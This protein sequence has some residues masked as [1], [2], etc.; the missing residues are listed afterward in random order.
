[1]TNS[2]KFRWLSL[3]THTESVKSIDLGNE[4]TRPLRI[5]FAT[6]R[7]LPSIGGTE[8]HTY[9]VAT[10]AAA[11]GC[12]VTVLTTDSSGRL[13]AREESNGI[14]ILRVRAWPRDWDYYFAPGIYRTIVRGHWDLIHCQGYHTLLA[15][16]VMLAAWRSRTPYILTFH[17]GGHSSHLRNALRGVQR[18]LL[19]PL[20]ARAPRLIAV[21]TFEAEFFRERLRLPTEQFVVIPNGSYLPASNS[22]PASGENGTLIVSVGRLERYKGHHRVIAALPWLV[23]HYPDVRLRIVGAGPFEPDLQRIARKL[24]VAD[25]VEINAIPAD[26]REGMTTVLN[27]A[28]LVILLS[29]YESQGM[30]VMEALALGR[31]V[32]VANTSGLR[33]LAER[34]FAR[35]TLSDSTPQEVA[36]AIREQLSCPLILG[37][38]AL[39]TW[40]ECAAMLLALYQDVIRDV[41]APPINRRRFFAR[42][43][44]GTRRQS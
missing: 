12:E 28:A 41:A 26:D 36:E 27:S 21:S 14:R 19:R 40:E 9:E 8:I 35:T 25:R 16:L 44:G 31:P 33:E 15:P 30:A 2:S 4:A 38:I 29:D 32:L 5:L 43:R 17:S 3:T 20:L 34:G 39:P 11:A 23:P 22:Q 6:A 1:M 7:Y 24:G 18:A 10:R 42:Y 13:R 37:K